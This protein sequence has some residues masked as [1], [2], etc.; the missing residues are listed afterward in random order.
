MS[1]KNEKLYE[2]LHQQLKDYVKNLKLENMSGKT[3]SWSHK[4]EKVCVI[5]FEGLP[6]NN[7]TEL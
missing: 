2:A 5:S 7:E 6:H 3:H 1:S 4:G